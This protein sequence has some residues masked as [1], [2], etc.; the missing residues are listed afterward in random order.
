MYHISGIRSCSNLTIPIEINEEVGFGCVCTL[1]NLLLF[2]LPTRYTCQRSS[3]KKRKGTALNKW[4][5]RLPPSGGRLSG[6]RAGNSLK[7]P[8]SRLGQILS[9]CSISTSEI[10]R[11]TGLLTVL[12][13][14]LKRNVSIFSIVDF[15]VMQN[16]PKECAPF[17]F[18]PDAKS[19]RHINLLSV[20]VVIFFLPP[21]SSLTANSLFR[22]SAVSHQNTVSLAFIHVYCN[23]GRCS[24]FVFKFE[25]FIL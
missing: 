3:F 24:R 15:F 2:P 6:G 21:S 22:P 9:W 10:P 23:A 12:G 13:N 7:I 4:G 17:Q 11:E 5:G 18:R 25:S 16:N 1:S 14:L 19:Q 8:W 20:V